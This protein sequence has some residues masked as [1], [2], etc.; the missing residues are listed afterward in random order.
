[1][2]LVGRKTLQISRLQKFGGAK[3]VCN[4]KLTIVSFSSSV[5]AAAIA[6]LCSVIPCVSFLF[7]AFAN[8]S[9]VLNLFIKSMFVKLRKFHTNMKN[10]STAL[11]H[12]VKL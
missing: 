7:L 5:F 2:K 11:L 9:I 3:D 1:M 4:G 6:L 12:G 8:S 10:C